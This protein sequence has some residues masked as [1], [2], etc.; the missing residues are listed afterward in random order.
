MGQE[1]GKKWAAAA[2]SQP[3][4]PKSDRLLATPAATPFDLEQQIGYQ[5]RRIVALL[6]AEITR[7]VEPLGLTDAQW[8]PMLRLLLGQEGTVAALAR[9]CHMDAGGMTRLL[10]RLEAKGLC[11]R[12]RSAQD[13]RVVHTE[14]TDAGRAVA[15]QLPAIFDALQAQALQGFDAAEVA[16]LQALIQ[17]IHDNLQA[18]PPAAVGDGVHSSSHEHPAP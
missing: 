11:T 6:G 14:L 4:I 2:H 18:L 3:T 13:R 15:A 1:A 5:L 16:Q 12:V 7:R 10:D 9:S 17:R 8:K